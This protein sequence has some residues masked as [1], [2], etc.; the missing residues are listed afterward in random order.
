MTKPCIKTNLTL[1]VQCTKDV[2]KNESHTLTPGILRT[3]G[4]ALLENR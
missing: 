1:N 3:E 4:Q 2:L